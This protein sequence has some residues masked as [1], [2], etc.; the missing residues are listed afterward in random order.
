MERITV[1]LAFSGKLGVSSFALNTSLTLS[2]DSAD[3]KVYATIG[4][5]SVKG[6]LDSASVSTAPDRGE[7]RW[8]ATMAAVPR[9]V[10]IGAQ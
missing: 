9:H 3:G 2:V 8:S 10:D 4:P 7:A 6:S 5:I 1:P